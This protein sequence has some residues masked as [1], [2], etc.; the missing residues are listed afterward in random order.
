MSTVRYV[1]Q[2]IFINDLLLNVVDINISLHK[3]DQ[4]LNDL[5]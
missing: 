2:Y 5:T 1:L 4:S 3:F